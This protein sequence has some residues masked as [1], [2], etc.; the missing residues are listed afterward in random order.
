MPDPKKPDLPFFLS[1][2]EIANWTGHWHANR[3][4]MISGELSPD[5]LKNTSLELIKL[6]YKSDEPITLMIESGGGNVIATHH[7]GDVIS[8]LECPVDALVIGNCAS[9]A[10][11][12]VQM[13]R[14]RVLMPSARMLVHYIRNDQLWVCD[15]VDQ[16]ENDIT[17]FRERMK[18]IA[19]RRLELYTR[20]TGFSREKISDMF[21]QGEVHRVF[22][23]AKQAIALGL[24][25]EI[26]TDFKIFKKKTEQKP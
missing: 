17:Y 24:A 11:D 19:E 13:C 22:F 2:N 6:S 16:L 10:V 1:H 23:T 26:A 14:R 8:M 3:R 15:D 25:D 21:R 18:E 20:R 9:M 5:S 4:V 12:L 7:L